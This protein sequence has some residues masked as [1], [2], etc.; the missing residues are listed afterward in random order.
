MRETELRGRV[1]DGAWTDWAETA[2]GDP[3]WFGGMDE[4]QI[5]THG[6][7]PAG[8]IHYVSVSEGTPRASERAGARAMPNVISRKQWGARQEERRLQTAAA[9]RLR[10]GEGGERPPH[11]LGRRLLA[12]GGAGLVLGIC[13]FHRNSNGWN[14]I[15]YNALVDRFGNIY[16]GRAGG[17]GRAVIGAQAAGR[18]RPDDRS[19]RARHPHVH[20]RFQTGEEGPRQMARLEAAGA[21]T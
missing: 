17:L 11:G 10:E 2:N 8:R 19:G 13:R 5:R 14:D 12:V 7:K 4:L 15:G 6:W 16:E 21:R 9:G 18:E 1:Q 3:V 20:A